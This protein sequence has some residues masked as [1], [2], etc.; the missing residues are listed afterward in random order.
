MYLTSLPSPLFLFFFFPLSITG[1]NY[2]CIT[3]RKS[4]VPVEWNTPQSISPDEKMTQF[5]IILPQLTQFLIQE[6]PNLVVSALRVW[7]S[8]RMCVVLRRFLKRRTHRI[9]IELF[10]KVQQNGDV[11][12]IF[13]AKKMDCYVRV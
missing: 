11:M 1:S 4:I 2:V 7:T 12:S 3:A 6:L 8:S 5:L 9:A 10:R 13:R